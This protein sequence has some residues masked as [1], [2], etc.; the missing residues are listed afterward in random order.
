MILKND[1]HQIEA[2]SNGEDA[3][4]KLGKGNYD[5]VFTDHIMG[6]MSGEELARTIKA[7]YTALPSLASLSLETI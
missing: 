6:G 2:V 3:L 7:K 5:F 1:G 4:K